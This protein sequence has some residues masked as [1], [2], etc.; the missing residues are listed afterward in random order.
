MKKIIVTISL[1]LVGMTSSFAQ[2]ENDTRE[3]FEMGAKAGINI[4]NVYDEEGGN[5][6]ANSKAGFAGGIFFSI[7]LNKYI[8]IQP[9]V[10]FSQK[11]FQSTRTLA[12]GPF[13]NNYTVNY[14]TTT[15][16]IDIPLQLQIKPSPFLTLVAGP[17]YSFVL[18]KED[19]RTDSNGN[20]NSTQTDYDNSNIRRN[21]FGVVGGLDINISHLV[22]SGRAGWDL[23]NNNGDGTSTNPRYK[24]AWYQ[25]TAG[26]KF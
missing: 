13:F 25:F 1:L 3:E 6:V 9:E 22:I 23:Q 18:S 15:N 11:G 2:D 17:Q 20:V 14:T 8:G 12:L 24:N 4:S 26:V 7:P 21:I 10:L 19:K 16:H 5:F